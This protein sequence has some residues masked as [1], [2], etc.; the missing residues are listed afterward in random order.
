L[1]TIIDGFKYVSS[2]LTLVAFIV[3]IGAWIFV[4][5]VRADAEKIRAAPKEDRARIVNALLSHFN[6]DTENLTPDYCFILAQQ[7]IEG[8]DRRFKIVAIAGLIAM[9]IGASVVIIS[10]ILDH[11]QQVE[12]AKING[13]MQKHETA[14]A[15]SKA[16][17]E[18]APDQPEK[19]LPQAQDSSSTTEALIE[20]PPGASLLRKNSLRKNQ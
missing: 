6:V 8:R 4:K 17:I 1:F 2:G 20:A 7:Q 14:Q 10:I 15:S 11:I 16:L 13:Y 18:Q 19:E 3:T 5:T 12:A 9:L